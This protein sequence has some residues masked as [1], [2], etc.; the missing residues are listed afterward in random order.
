MTGSLST[1]MPSA[2]AARRGAVFSRLAREEV[3]V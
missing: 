1:P 3:F 2:F